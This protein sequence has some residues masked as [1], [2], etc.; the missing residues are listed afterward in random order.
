MDFQNIIGKFMTEKVGYTVI[1][2]SDTS[3]IVYT[4]PLY[5]EKCGEDI[6]G[7]KVGEVCGWHQECPEL[8]T[9][10]DA[11]EW[12]YIDASDKKYYSIKSARF[13]EEK[14][15]YEI[16]LLTDITGYMSLNRDVTKYM[17]FFKKLSKFQTAV[18]EKLSDTYYELLPLVA[19]YLKTDRTCFLL[20]RGD[21]V[22]II[23]FDRKEKNYSNER[24]SRKEAEKQ[25]LFAEDK[26]KGQ[27]GDT[28]PASGDYTLISG[29]IS[30]D[31]YAVTVHNG[32]GTD[33]DAL[34]E[35]AF[36]SVIRLYIENGVMREKLVYESEHDGLTGLLNKGKYLSM[37][38][39]NFVG[40]DSIA[41]FNFDVNNLKKMNDL[42]G[43]EAGD[44]LIIKS[45][46]SIRKV[47]N[48]KVH[49]FRMGGD[50]FLM[51][52][53]NVTRKETDTIK[54]RWE[55]ELA[56]LNTADDGINCVIALGVAYGEKGYDY[57]AL[58]K[59]ADE[60]MYEDKKSKKKPGEEIR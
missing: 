42:F 7:K 21:N 20:Q 4:D 17:G 50:E 3:E 18:L 24:I 39:K 45:A 52:A 10:G 49:G 28:M 56:R 40:L 47:I 27:A 37:A 11:V 55:E 34:R 46:D 2:C 23:T 29:E 53:E 48:N 1:V 44:K 59:L 32:L 36:K 22:E 6:T 31:R 38:E 15:E 60:R 51:V 33:R 9:D 43:H 41:I 12:E 35:P 14:R 26:E 16:H 8:I 25:G 19:D 30:G 54:K 5:L 13:S 57:A 58:L